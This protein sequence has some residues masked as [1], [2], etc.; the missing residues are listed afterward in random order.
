MPGRQVA[1]ARQIGDKSG[2]QAQR[3][4]V[5]GLEFQGINPI[6]PGSLLAA[7]FHTCI[8]PCKLYF[9]A[10]VPCKTHVHA[11]F[12]TNIDRG[13]DHGR[14]GGKDPPAPFWG[15][16]KRGENVACVHVNAPRFRS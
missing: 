2:R 14:L 3:S 16:L 9:K 5:Q 6:S 12:D 7:P 8:S 10:F 11:R 1:G 13:G 4:R 15:T